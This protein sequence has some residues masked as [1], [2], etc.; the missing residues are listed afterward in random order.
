MWECVASNPETLNP[1]SPMASAIAIWTGE[2]K[3]KD[4]KSIFSHYHFPI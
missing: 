2:E 1:F 4:K 3:T